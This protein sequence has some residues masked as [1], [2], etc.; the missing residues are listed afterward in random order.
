MSVHFVCPGGDVGG[1]CLELFVFCARP[2]GGR[3]VPPLVRR[4]CRRS[5]ALGIVGPCCLCR[6]AESADG[7]VAVGDALLCVRASGDD[8]CASDRGKATTGWRL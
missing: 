7:Q 1:E 3:P 2:A 6:H 4:Q 5:V 8:D